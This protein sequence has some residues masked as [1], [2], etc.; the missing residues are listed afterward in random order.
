MG[1]KKP[2]IIIQARMNSTR[3]P[4][5][6]MKKVNGESL[7]EHLITRLQRCELTKNIYVA[8]PAHHKS[9]NNEK[10]ILDVCRKLGVQVYLGSEKDLLK[11]YYKCAVKY[12]IDPVVR[13]TSDCPLMDP[14]VVDEAIDCFV[15]SRADYFS[16]YT[17][18]TD[19]KG[20]EGYPS[21]QTVEVIKFSLLK[22]LYENVSDPNLREHCT[23]ALYDEKWSKKFMPYVSGLTLDGI[24]KDIKLSVDTKEDFNF[25]KDIL[26]NV[27][28]YQKNYTLEDVITYLH[29]KDIYEP[30]S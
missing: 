26:E 1:E 21:G 23:A 25:V 4:G 14:V 12:D 5:K 8:A 11:R 6:I 27:Y 17:K 2:G 3:L 30:T 28:P 18:M 7:L 22:T 15:H 10:P 29:Y 19:Y 9:L 16:N 20:S 13:I 24:Y